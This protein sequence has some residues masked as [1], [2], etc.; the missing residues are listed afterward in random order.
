MFP[1]PFAFYEPGEPPTFP[2][3][4]FIGSLGSCTPSQSYFSIPRGEASS[5]DIRVSGD[6]D[7]IDVTDYDLQ[8]KVYSDAFYKN[9]IFTKSSLGGSIT[10]M[11]P[12]DGLIRVI[13]TALD[14]SLLPNIFFTLYWQLII[15]P[16]TIVSNGLLDILST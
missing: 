8:F 2:P 7:P 1:I 14:T 12:L 16:S 3:P 13:F 6:V 5:F 10:K 15:L 4:P 9:T 11:F